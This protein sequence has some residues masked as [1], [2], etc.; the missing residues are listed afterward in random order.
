[1]E[2]VLADELNMPVDEWSVYVMSGVERGMWIELL[3]LGD[4]GR[5]FIMDRSDNYQ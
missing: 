2:K 4:Y 1:M 3:R 5:I